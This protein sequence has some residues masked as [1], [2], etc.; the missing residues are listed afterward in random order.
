MSDAEPALRH[1]DE[2][3]GVSVTGLFWIEW[4][5]TGC[6]SPSHSAGDDISFLA[7]AELWHG[8][9]GDT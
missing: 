7:V 5:L 6:P 9:G 1:A 4:K 2:G 3:T 8:H